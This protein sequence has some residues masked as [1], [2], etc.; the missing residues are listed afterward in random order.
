MGLE[1]PSKYPEIDP[2]RVSSS[3]QGL[4]LLAAGRIDLSVDERELILRPSNNM[5]IGAPIYHAG[6]LY[7]ETVF[8]ALHQKH[9]TLADL[10]AQELR[11][12]LNHDKAYLLPFTHQS[13]FYV[14]I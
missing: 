11:K 14:N 6:L 5:D 13:P 7:E 3:S 4:E 8:P 9:A 12:Q 10:L 1:P 2:T